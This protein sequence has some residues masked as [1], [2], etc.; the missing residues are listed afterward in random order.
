MVCLGLC[1]AQKP[2]PSLDTGGALSPLS[3]TLF[4]FAQICSLCAS[5]DAAGQPLEERV[6]ME[7]QTRF[8]KVVAA[9]DIYRELCQ[10]KVIPQTVVEKITNSHRVEEARGHLFDHMRD[11]GTLATLKV[12]CDVISSD[13][14]NG[15]PA[16]QDFGTE[17][18]RRLV[19]G[20]RFVCVCVWWCADGT[21]SF[22]P[23]NSEKERARTLDGQH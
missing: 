1:I 21:K 11:Y 10:K 13:K 17:L 9:K 7:C 18:R 2:C 4:Q 15:F 6:L 20:G 16:M 3:T 23:M 14:Y 12:F 22:G 8:L 19:Q 5:F